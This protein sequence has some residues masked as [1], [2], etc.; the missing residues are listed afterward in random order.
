M[1]ACARFLLVALGLAAIAALILPDAG[2]AAPPEEKFQVFQV[3]VEFV[4][5]FWTEQCGFEVLHAVRGKFTWSGTR[6]E[7]GNLVPEIV[8]VQGVENSLIGPTGATL[9]FRDT[10]VN[11]LLTVNPDGSLTFSA[12]GVLAL[13]ITV[14][15]KGLV[16]ANIG[17]SV[18]TWVFDESGNVIDE[19]VEFEV[20]PRQAD[21]GQA[22]LDAVCAALT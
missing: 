6:D 10:G 16:L 14:P 7:E 9:S 2:R 3:D 5:E 11:R 19:V 15:G 12:S 18:L 21:F 13:R 22:G 4:D 20:G 1:H 8:R 17:R